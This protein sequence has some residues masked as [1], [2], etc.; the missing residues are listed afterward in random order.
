MLLFDWTLTQK[1]FSAT[2]KDWLHYAH[3]RKGGTPR[4]AS[5]ADITQRNASQTC[6]YIL[7][8]NIVLYWTPA[9]TVS[10]NVHSF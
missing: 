10:K 1:D 5:A 7:M 8:D 6:A 3:K 4:N 2:V 9:L